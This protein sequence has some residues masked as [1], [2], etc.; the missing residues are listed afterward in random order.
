MPLSDIP[1]VEI[2]LF[3]LENEH[4]VAPVWRTE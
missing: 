4:D 2:D 3:E 1:V